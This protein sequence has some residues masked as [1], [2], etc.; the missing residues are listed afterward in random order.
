ML[1]VLVVGR[2]LTDQEIIVIVMKD[3]SLWKGKLTVLFVI[4]NA[5]LVNIL[6]KIVQLVGV[7]TDLLPIL[8]VTVIMGGLR[9]LLLLKIVCN[10]TINALYVVEVMLIV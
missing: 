2:G 6:L 8:S 9:T 7:L 10:V 4:L 3:I 5:L 1:F